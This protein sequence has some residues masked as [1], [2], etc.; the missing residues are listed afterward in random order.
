VKRRLTIARVAFFIAALAFVL[1]AVFPLRLALDWLGLDERGF[2]AREATGTIWI[3]ALK[4]AQIG[5][6]PLGDLETRLHTLPLFLGRARISLT[7]DDEADPFRGAVSVSRHAFGIDDVS[8]RLPVGAAI[9]PIPIGQ[10]ELVDVSAGFESGLCT[11]GEGQVRAVLSGEAAAL[12]LPA[13]LTGN[14]R[15]AG[16]ALLL[17]FAGPA[18]MERLQFRLFADGRYRADLAVRVSDTRIGARLTAAGFLSGRE[19]F[20]RVYEGRF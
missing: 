17:G 14:V 4:E 16:D 7:R 15:C 9:A 3:G 20:V 2:A 6:V 5:P 19:G 13:A 18:G 11:R 10:I 1:V 12:G 8:G